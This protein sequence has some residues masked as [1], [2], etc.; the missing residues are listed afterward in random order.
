MKFS[1]TASI[2]RQ[3][4]LAGTLAFLLLAGC[5]LLIIGLN[6]SGWIFT[7]GCCLIEIGY[8]GARWVTGKK[9]HIEWLLMSAKGFITRWREKREESK[10]RRYQA[11]EWAAARDAHLERQINELAELHVATRLAELERAEELRSR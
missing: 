10:A 2:T 8:A 1:S 7:A 9:S 5:C 6:H 4:I 11:R 3:V